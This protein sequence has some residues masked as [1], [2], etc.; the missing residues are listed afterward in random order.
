MCMATLFLFSINFSAH[1]VMSEDTTP[2]VFCMEGDRG[3][4]KTKNA[5]PHDLGD[6]GK[7][8]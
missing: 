4:Y 7:L 6:P 3:I 1:A 2:I 5:V 8:C